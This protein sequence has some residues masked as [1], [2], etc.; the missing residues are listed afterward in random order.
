[1]SKKKLWTITADKFLNET[2]VGRLLASLDDQLILGLAKC[3]FQP[4]K[5]VFIV[6]TLLETGLRVNEFC[7]LIHSDVRGNKLLVRIAKGGRPRTVLLTKSAQR[8]LRQWIDI[9]AK[10]GLDCSEES[11][12]FPSRYGKACTTRAISYRVKIQYQNAHLDQRFSVHTLRHTH[13]SLML[14]SNQVGLAHLRNNMGHHSLFTLDMYSH[15]IGNLDNVELFR[16]TS[17]KRDKSEANLG[18]AY[19][20]AN[21]VD[22]TK[23]KQ[24]QNQ[25]KMRNW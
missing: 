19:S 22:L 9:K 18:N 6:K 23:R 13:C 12:L 14:A 24:K 5:D 1:M 10:I 17:E 3:R 15:A 11:P 2:E 7:H 16:L 25:L 20:K 8:C 21:T 4:I